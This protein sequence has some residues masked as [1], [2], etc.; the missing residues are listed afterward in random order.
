MIIFAWRFSWNYAYIPFNFKVLDFTFTS[1]PSMLARLIFAGLSHSLKNM[2]PRFGCTTI[3][4]GLF[5]SLSRVRR[6]SGVLVL[7]TFR[8]PFLNSQIKLE[9]QSIYIYIIKAA[10]SPYMYVSYIWPNGWTEIFWGTKAKKHFEL[11]FFKNRV[12]FF[13]NSKFFP[14]A[15]PDTWVR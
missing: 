6:L 1:V 3:A 13:Q 14:R 5:R 11:F 4:L 2:Y 12:F 10:L 7:S 8:V 9:L 15:T